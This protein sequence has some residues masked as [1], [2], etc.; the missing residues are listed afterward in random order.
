[1]LFRQR[2]SRSQGISSAH[3]RSMFTRRFDDPI[4]KALQL[5]TCANPSICGGKPETLTSVERAARCAQ[6]VN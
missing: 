4:L 2:T 5:H 3:R 6:A 1:M